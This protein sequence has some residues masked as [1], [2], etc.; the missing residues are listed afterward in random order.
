MSGSNTWKANDKNHIESEQSNTWKENDENHI[1]S[2]QHC[3]VVRT[4]KIETHK[5]QMD[6]YCVRPSTNAAIARHDRKHLLNQHR[7]AWRGP[8]RNI[9]MPMQC[10]YFP[11]EYINALKGKYLPSLIF[12]KTV[13]TDH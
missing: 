4:S 11:D 13:I 6:I 8:N 9:R 3:N 7:L 2:E 5:S 1:E 10:G 12:Y